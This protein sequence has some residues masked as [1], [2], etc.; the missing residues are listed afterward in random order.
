MA[1]RADYPTTHRPSPRYEPIHYRP[2]TDLHRSCLGCPHLVD[3]V[4]HLIPFEL[5]LYID[6]SHTS[7]TLDKD[8]QMGRERAQAQMEQR[9]VS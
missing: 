8:N 3:I 4:V 5:S 9:Y 7:F 2:T 6:V 1:V